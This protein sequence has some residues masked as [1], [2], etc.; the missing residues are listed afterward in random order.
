MLERRVVRDGDR[1]RPG[2]LPKGNPDFRRPGEIFRPGGAGGVG[3]PDGGPSGVDDRRS[4]AHRQGDV[5]AF[6]H[7]GG[8]GGQRDHP[9]YVIDG[10][11]ADRGQ[12]AQALVVAVVRGHGVGDPVRLSIQAG[13]VRHAELDELGFLPVC[14]AERQR[15]AQVHVRAAAR[16]R[17]HDIRRGLAAKA[18]GVAVAVGTHRHV[19]EVLQVQEQ[20]VAVVLDRDLDRGRRGNPGIVRD[21]MGQ[22]EVLVGSVVVLQGGDDDGLRRVPGSGGAGRERDRGRRSRRALAGLHGDGIPVGGGDRHRQCGGLAGIGGQLDVVAPRLS[23]FLQRDGHVVEQHA[24][25]RGA[26]VIDHRHRRLVFGMV[27]GIVV[28]AVLLLQHGRDHGAVLFPGRVV[29]GRHLDPGREGIAGK[30]HR[31]HAE[32]LGSHEVAPFPDPHPHLRRPGVAA[33]SAVPAP[34]HDEFRFA[35]FVHAG[36]RAGHRHR[37]PAVLVD[38]HHLGPGPGGM[39]RVA[40]TRLHLKGGEAVRAVARVVVGP[41]PDARGSRLIGLDGEYVNLLVNLG[42]FIPSSTLHH[43]V[44]RDIEILPWHRIGKQVEVP[45]ISFT[46]RFVAGLDAHDRRA[47]VVRDPDVQG[48]A[49]GNPSREVRGLQRAEGELQGPAVVLDLV[50]DGG[51][52]ELGHARTLARKTHPRILRRVG[53][54]L[55]Q[56]HL[57]AGIGEGETV[58]R[59][60]RAAGD[61]DGRL[62]GLPVL[63]AIAARLAKVEVDVGRAAAFQD[64]GA[65][66]RA[67]PVEPH[68]RGVVVAHR[69]AGFGTAAQAVVVAGDEGDRHLAV[70]LVAVVVLGRHVVVQGAG[71]GHG[72]RLRPLVGGGDVVLAGEF[73]DLELHVKRRGRGRGRRDAEAGVAALVRRRGPRLRLHADDGRGRRV[74]ERDHR[75]GDGTSGHRALDADRLV[76]FPGHVVLRVLQGERASGARR[77]RRNGDGEVRHRLV[78]RAP[79]GGAVAPAHLHRDRQGLVE[80]PAND[81]GGDGDGRRR[82]GVLGHPGLRAVLVGVGVQGEGDIRN[83]FV[84]ED[85]HGDAVAAGLGRR[86]AAEFGV[87]ALGGEVAEGDGERLVLGVAV[88]AGGGADFKVGGERRGAAADELELR[89]GGSGGRELHVGAGPGRQGQLEVAVRRLRRRDG[90]AGGRGDVEGDLQLLARREAAAERQGE[91]RLAGNVAL[92]EGNGGAGSER[93]LGGVVVRDRHLRVVRAAAEGVL[94]VARRLEGQGQGAVGPVRIV[95]PGR[96]RERMAGRPGREFHRGDGEV[97]VGDVSAFLG[98]DEIDRDLLRE[99]NAGVDGESGVRALGDAGAGRDV[100]LGA[101][102]DVLQGDD[103]AGDGDAV[104]R[105]AIDADGLVEFKGQVRG[106]REGEFGFGAGLVRRNLDLEIVHRVVV[107]IRGGGAGAA[108]DRH[109]DRLRLAEAGAARKGGGDGEGDARA[110]GLGDARLVPGGVR[111]RV[112][113][114]RDAGHGIVVGDLEAGLARSRHGFGAAVEAGTGVLVERAQGHLHGLGVA[115][116]EGIG[117]GGDLD[118]GRGAGAVLPRE[119]DGRRLGGEVGAVEVPVGHPLRLGGGRRERV[120]RAEGGGAGKSQRNG[121][122]L[123]IDQRAA[124]GDGKVESP[125]RLVDGALRRG[126]ADP[127]GVVVDD[128]DGGGD[129]VLGIEPGAGGALQDQGVLLAGFVDGVVPGDGLE[130]DEL[131]RAAGLEDDLAFRRREGVV[132]ARG[133]GGAVDGRERDLGVYFRVAALVDPE[134]DF[135]VAVAFRHGEGAS[136]CVVPDLRRV[137]LVGDGDGGRSGV[138]QRHPG[139]PSENPHAEGFLAFVNLAALVLV[140]GGHRGGADGEAGRDGDL[141]DPGVVRVLRRPVEVGQRHVEGAGRGQRP[142]QPGGEQDAAVLRHR[143]RCRGEGQGGVRGGSDSDRHRAEGAF[144]RRDVRRAVVVQDLR[145]TAA[146][147][148]GDGDGLLGV[149]GARLEGERAADRRHPRIAAD[150]RDGDRTAGLALELDLVGLAAAGGKAEA[151]GGDVHAGAV[152]FDIEADGVEGH[153]VVAAHCDVYRSVFTAVRVLVFLRRDGDRLRLVPVC[154]AEGQGRGTERDGTAT[155]VSFP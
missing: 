104:R 5:P 81:A 37:R 95:A 97:V 103:R 149:P 108:T 57:R 118:G 106:R 138:A 11:E 93:D 89:L 84:V 56:L 123:A 70:G 152:V 133:G 137:G 27:P 91:G 4:Q 115:L 78:V 1:R 110:V 144:G 76:P 42:A 45:V 13:V 61:D 71:D 34:R 125:V 126:Q 113:G 46:N 67:V 112:H 140:G 7:R 77:V 102:G 60:R 90:G 85:L 28:S 18:H 87:E 147:A 17:D 63:K 39:D 14:R 30:L 15:T 72:D 40:R 148:A 96:H 2:F 80:R 31:P 132:V 24:R 141:A 25:R 129:G 139:G 23:A 146:G 131:A 145:R 55:Q 150:R 107:R 136:A 88:V 58:V 65:C 73:G 128:G 151:G 79:G 82:A 119:D 49:P 86:A 41:K 19:A 12:A 8:I 22:R 29:Q 20:A 83:G 35:A 16:R 26:V 53:R 124:Q 114:Q 155:V 10:P 127:G 66:A 74:R 44:D 21:R 154:A 111:V 59:A 51:D 142:V 99:G 100:Q 135:G 47:V 101:V 116:V 3:Q 130:V 43:G 69:H 64:R 105:A 143:L 122:R 109:G 153:A 120:V 36:G 121:Q 52:P 134:L 117:P 33:R 68:L 75:A 62:D 50:V 6:R 32:M 9:A 94:A 48:I 54:R 92:G 98:E 38:N